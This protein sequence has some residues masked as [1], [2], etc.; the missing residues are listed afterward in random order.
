MEIFRLFFLIFSNFLFIAW[1]ASMHIKLFLRRMYNNN[2][3]DDDDANSNNNNTSR[4]SN[5]TTTTTS[6]TPIKP[7]YKFTEKHTYYAIT[8]IR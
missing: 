2:N 3:D 6:S 5:S 7:T 1:N 8:R 4:K